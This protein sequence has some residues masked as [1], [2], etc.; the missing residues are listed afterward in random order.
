M[1]P[2]GPIARRLRAE[3]EEARWHEQELA[4]VMEANVVRIS[5]RTAKV[6]VYLRERVERLH[7]AINRLERRNHVG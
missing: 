2:N 7:K 5:G 6:G 3:L 1:S 4:R